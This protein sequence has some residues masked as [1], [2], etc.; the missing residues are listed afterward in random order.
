MDGQPGRHVLVV[1][2]EEPVRRLLRRVVASRGYQCTEAA[3]AD[4]ALALLAQGKVDVI[5]LDLHMPGRYDGE[6]LLFLLRDR[7]DDVP[8]IVISGWVDDEVA[9]NHPDC[10]QAVLK[11]PVHNRDLLAALAQV[12]GQTS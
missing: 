5:L 1:D 10:V 6:E 2:D 3:N 4:E 12:F 8:I 11:K 9:G 7:G